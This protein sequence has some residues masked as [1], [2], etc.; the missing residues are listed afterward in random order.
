MSWNK[1]HRW[2]WLIPVLLALAFNLNVLQNGFG[3]DDEWIIPHLKSPDH[4]T[5]LFLPGLPPPHSPKS[6][7]VHFRPLTTVSYILD[8]EL[9][10]DRPLGFHLSVYLAHL[11]NTALLFFLTQSLL[12][13]PQPSMRGSFP[14]DSPL[15]PQHLVPLLAASLFAVHPVHAE[16][17]AWIAGRNDVFCTFF[18]LASLLLY[19]RFHR[20]GHCRFFALSML[21]FFL[22]LLTKEIAVVLILLF[23]LY[24]FLSMERG[25]PVPWKRLALRFTIPLGILITYFWMRSATLQFLPGGSS[26]PATFSLSILSEII[27]AY[28]FY[29]DL[30]LF[31]YPHNPFITTMPRSNLFLFSSVFILILFITAFIFAVV[32]R[33]ILLGIGLA[34]TVIFIAP[35]AGVAAFHLAATP[36]AERY[37]Y[38]PS[39][40]ILMLCA[41][42]LFKGAERHS[43]IPAI[44]STAVKSNPGF[45][46]VVVLS[47]GIIVLWGWQSR[48]RNAVWLSPV[49]F[50]EAA[51]AA[52]PEA[53]F[54]HRLLGIQYVSTG[55]YP[56]AEEQFRQAIANFQKTLGPGHL[57]VADSLYDL[58]NLY[59]DQGKYAE[60][61][62]LYLRVIP[63]WKQVLGPDHPD[64]ANAL[65][66]LALI[67]QAQGRYAEAES[68]FRQALEVSVKSLNPDDPRLGVLL[69]NYA[70]LLRSMHRE[71]E[72]VRLETQAREILTHSSPN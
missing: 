70:H 30:M 71:D 26:S 15:T 11:L 20:T 56:E 8:H 58:A 44:K 62:P 50:W 14:D 59:N 66:N 3:W 25:Q 7:Y 28:G 17:V 47:A 10:G 69:E 2:S 21:T 1:F 13:L 6:A 5:D 41:W 51:V 48:T 68:L 36:G 9:W 42:L 60:A 12:R 27:R 55:R 63:I 37:V 49:S 24:E 39:A 61:E 16:A 19:L 31:P 45:L 67:S 40:G 72:A 29:I 38:A 54:P 34:W 52:S 43:L 18:L 22:A 53:G 33:Q 46:L 57:A 32:R 64:L 23:P 35:A 4:W 65:H